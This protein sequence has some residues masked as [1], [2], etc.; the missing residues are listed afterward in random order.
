[1][2]LV[3]RVALVLTGLMVGLVIGATSPAGGGPLRGV[4]PSPGDRV[5]VT[6]TAT[7]CTVGPPAAVST[8]VGLG[9]VCRVGGDYRAR[10]GVVINDGEVAITRYT[11]F[12]RYRVIVRKQQSPVPPD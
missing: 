10:Y 6:G 4:Y 2:G 12:N 1:M 7:S 5:F 9:F 3:T 8:G 11:G